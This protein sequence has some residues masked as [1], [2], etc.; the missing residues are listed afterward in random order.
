MSN[1]KENAISY[2]PIYFNLIINILYFILQHLRH[3]HN[4]KK[5]ENIEKEIISSQKLESQRNSININ[6]LKNI[7]N[8]YINDIEKNNV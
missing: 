2:A 8:E 4:I 7:I 1:C 5:M 6:D 3:K